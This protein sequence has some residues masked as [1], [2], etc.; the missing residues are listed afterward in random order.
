MKEFFTGDIG[1]EISYYANDLEDFY[2]ETMKLT[3]PVNSSGGKI[4]LII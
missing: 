2:E 3:S 4:Y 1:E